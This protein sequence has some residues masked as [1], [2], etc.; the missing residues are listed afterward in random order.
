MNMNQE[1]QEGELCDA[2]LN[3]DEP[4]EKDRRRERYLKKKRR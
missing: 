2:F 1:E 4:S 3:Y